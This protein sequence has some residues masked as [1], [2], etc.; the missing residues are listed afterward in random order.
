MSGISN[1]Y[2]KVIQAVH[3]PG[4]AFREIA[5]ITTAPL[6]RYLFR[7]KYGDGCDIMEKDWDNLLILDACR[8]DMFKEVNTIS[9]E[10]DFVMSK[11]SHS[12]EFYEKN[13]KDKSYNDTIMISANPYTPI[14]AE[15]AFFHLKTTLGGDRTVGDKPRVDKVETEDG[16]VIDATH[17]DNVHPERL[18][19][20]ALEAIEKHPDK[21][22]IVHYMQPHDPYLGRAAEDIRETF[23]ENGYTFGYWADPDSVSDDDPNGLMTLAKE[24]HLSPEEM[25]SVYKEN[26]RIVLE[27]CSKL[28]SE[29]DGK[30][31]ITADH[32]ELLG[33]QIGSKRFFHY[34]NMY[35]EELRKVPWL[36]VE[37]NK[38][39]K[40]SKDTPISED[41][42]DERDLQEHLELL[43]YK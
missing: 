25:E 11:G 31:V 3:N 7:R 39:R 23:N 1:Q 26:L 15:D 35:V 5:R 29:I 28:L 14:I 9:G 21:R 16:R 38:R 40:I 43:G 10:L 36:T 33:E 24:D 27:Y 42:I 17:I 34:N 22:L 8:F 18:N 2:R 20:M 13:F 19:R 32:G 37:S 12:E 41:T 4:L 30:T 6:R